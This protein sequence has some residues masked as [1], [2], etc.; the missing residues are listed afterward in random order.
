MGGEGGAGADGLDGL[1]ER[2]AF[3]EDAAAHALQAEEA[4]VTLV[5]M[6]DLGEGVDLLEGADAADA[7]EDL[8]LEA[9]LGVAAVETVGD[10]PADLGVLL[11]RR[12]E[13]VE[14]DAA[15]LGPPESGQERRAGQ[16]DLDGVALDR[17]EGHGVGVEGDVALLL[18]AVAVELLAEVAVGVE[19]ADADQGDAEGAGRLE[20]VA[21]EHAEAARVLG[22]GLGDA[23]LG[24][25]V[26]DRPQRGVAS[27]E[28]TVGLEVALQVV[29]DF[30]EEGHEGAVVGELLEAVAPDLAEEADGILAG[31]LP[32]LGVDP[33][34]KVL[35]PLVPRPAQVHGER[36]QGCQRRRQ[37]RPDG[38]AS[39]GPHWMRRVLG[40]ALRAEFALGLVAGGRP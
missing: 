1:V 20:V 38:E 13:Q 21:G 5:A 26:G 3:L 19:E 36:L 4:G 28:P 39:I 8:L 9:V 18:P 15:D 16:V 32:A 12:V 40:K 7:E 37:A 6:E 24:R 14:R 35:G 33:P 30:A 23:E 34:E 2:Q 31:G 25:E 27:L 11:D 29:V 22:E 10:V 17:R